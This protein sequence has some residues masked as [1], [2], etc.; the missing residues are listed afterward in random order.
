[1]RL[2]GAIY[3]RLSVTILG[4]SVA[5]SMRLS[6]PIMMLSM[7]ILSLIV[8]IY[9]RLIVAISMRLSEAISMRLR[10]A[11]ARQYP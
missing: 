4:F 5:M 10:V 2:S 7:A 11:I 1:M 8:A 6:E 3:I 9:M